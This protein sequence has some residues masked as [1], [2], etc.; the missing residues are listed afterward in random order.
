MSRRPTRSLLPRACVWPVSLSGLWSCLA[1]S[2]KKDDATEQTV[3]F[4]SSQ[5]G[6]PTSVTRQ[7]EGASQVLASTN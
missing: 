2:E 6:N 4:K 1:R 7:T 3:P 5:T